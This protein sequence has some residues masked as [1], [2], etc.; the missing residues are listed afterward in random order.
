MDHLHLILYIVGQWFFIMCINQD[1]KWHAVT[2]MNYVVD[3][4]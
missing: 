2:D 3:Y 4:H 1:V